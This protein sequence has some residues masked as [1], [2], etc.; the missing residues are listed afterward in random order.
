MYMKKIVKESIRCIFESQQKNGLWAK[1]N[2]I[3]VS[4]KRGNVYSL[5][6]EMLDVL[7]LPPK[8]AK[9]FTGYLDNLQS[10]IDWISDKTI[11]Y[12]KEK[13][14]ICGWRSNHIAN[15]KGSPISWSTA[16]VFNTMFKIQSF[17]ALLLNEAIV[18]T[19]VPWRVFCMKSQL[20]LL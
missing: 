3:F 9:T 5:A 18:S 16:I 2:P 12:K 7:F 14:D 13:N 8:Y 15:P 19:L 4:P 10:I 1:S 20:V 6:F 17:V 11:N